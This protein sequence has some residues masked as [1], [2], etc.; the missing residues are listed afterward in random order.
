[1]L[2]TAIVATLQTHGR[3]N[4]SFCIECMDVIRLLIERNS[5][6]LRLTEAGICGGAYLTLLVCS[7]ADIASFKFISL[8]WLIFC[9]IVMAD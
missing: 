6:K 2:V 8:F 7:G 5:T 9:G 4:E 3:M 1:M